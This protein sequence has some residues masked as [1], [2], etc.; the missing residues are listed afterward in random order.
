[1]L[2]HCA[3]QVQKR[4]GTKVSPYSS[5]QMC[6]ELQLT[7]SSRT[8]IREAQWDLIHTT[9]IG[10]SWAQC[11][12]V[13]VRDGVHSPELFHEQWVN[14][15]VWVKWDFLTARELIELQMLVPCFALTFTN[16]SISVQ[17]HIWDGLT[18]APH[19]AAQ[20]W[21]CSHSPL[22]ALGG[23]RPLVGCAEGHSVPCSRREE[24]VPAF[25]PSSSFA[26]PRGAE[27]IT[28]Y[29]R[30]TIINLQRLVD[31]YHLEYD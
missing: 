8:G 22:S 30:S 17:T 12:F 11:V 23:M 10:K 19:W 15:S 2:Q 14:C 9:Y 18:P 20:Q 3:K 16:C 13:N 29:M 27:F 31:L 6:A 5:V 24:A 25:I 28:G 7:V 4:V 26:W 21:L 1:M